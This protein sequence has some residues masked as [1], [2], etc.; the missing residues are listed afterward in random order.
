LQLLV[1]FIRTNYSS[2]YK[3]KY[4]RIFFTS[5]LHQDGPPNSVGE[6]VTQ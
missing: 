2:N 1:G 5:K 4:T 6:G 3:K